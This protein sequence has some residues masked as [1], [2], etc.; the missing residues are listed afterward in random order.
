MSR[1]AAALVAALAIAGPMPAALAA[2]PYDA[3]TMASGGTYLTRS[4]DANSPYW[5]PANLHNTR[6]VAYLG[7]NTGFLLGNNSLAVGD[8]WGAFQPT[9]TGNFGAFVNY[10]QEIR[11]YRD[12]IAQAIK[13]SKNPADPPKSVALPI[14][15]EFRGYLRSDSGLFGL[16]VAWGGQK[17]LQKTY[18]DEAASADVVVDLPEIPNNR[19][20]SLRTYIRAPGADFFVLAPSLITGLDAVNKLDRDMAVELIKLSKEMQEGTMDFSQI[21]TRVNT[22]KGKLDEGLKPLLGA[23]GNAITIGMNQGAYLTNALSYQMPLSDFQFIHP[24]LASTSV[25]LGATARIHTGPNTLNIN[26][27]NDPEKGAFSVFKGASTTLPG[28]FSLVNT[29]NIKQPVEKLKAALDDFASN[30]ASGSSLSSAAGDFLSSYKT[31]FISH[32]A[33]PVGVSLDFGTTVPLGGGF[34]LA[35]MLQNAPTFWPSEKVTLT[36]VATGTDFNFQESKKEFEN[37]TYTEPLGVRLGVGWHADTPVIGS[38]ASLEVAEY[39]DGPSTKNFIGTPS[40]NLG[41]YGHFL[42]FFYGRIGTQ[43]GGKGN[44]IAGG[45]GLNFGIARLE[46]SGGIEP[47]YGAIKFSD[48]TSFA[49]SMRGVGLGLTFNLGL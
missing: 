2:E 15:D 18:F 33:G 34:A 40:L 47:D 46:F 21:K 11:A 28:R 36:N 3:S 26:P 41:W 25:N 37:F 49:T 27:L 30:P 10:I 19:G 7:A 1:Y 48:P 24:D 8:V 42:Q 23:E 32:K 17:A 45:A 4:V 44:L 6:G 16:N 39:L 38:G 29:F 22:I 13:D 14:P 5:N 35:A 31:E 43:V 9:P 20:F 12:G